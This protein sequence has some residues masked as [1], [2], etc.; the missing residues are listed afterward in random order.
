MVGKT[1][2]H[3]ISSQPTHPMTARRKSPT[4][5]L[6]IAND[7]LFILITCVRDDK[8]FVDYWFVMDTFTAC[9]CLPDR[10]RISWKILKCC[11]G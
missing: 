8:L 6:T 10:L 3:P 11:Y 4:T 7:C 5:R 2:H 1:R 9:K